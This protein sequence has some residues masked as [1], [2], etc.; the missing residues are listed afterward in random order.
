MSFC[1]TDFLQSGSIMSLPQNKLLL[2]WGEPRRFSTKAIDSHKPAFYFTDFFLTTAQPWI[3]YSQWMEISYEDFNYQLQS[4]VQPSIC[5]WNICKPEQFKQT[6]DELKQLLQTGQLQKGVP[7]L[8]AHSS[9]CMDEKRL[10]FCLAKS[11]DA[12]KH[13]MGYLYGHWHLSSGVLGLTPELLLSHTQERPNRVQTMALAGTCHPSFCQESFLKNEKERYEHQLVVEGISQSLQPFGTIKIKEIQLLHLPKL[14]HLMTPIEVELD[15]AF[16][17]DTLVNTLHP[18]PALG[19]YPPE[20][21]KKWLQH[22]QE[23]IPRHYYGAP[24]GFHDFRNGISQCVVGIRNV[25]WN[26]SGMRIGAGCGVIKQSSFDKEWQEIQLKIQS[27]R[28]QFN[29]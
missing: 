29:L 9:H 1:L 18:T 17:F 25:Q 26:K 2:G 15:H 7:Y 13:Q 23:Q 19:A 14:T 3:Q 4:V 20:E 10:Q 24:L 12:M 11:L 28:D 5:N 21:G 8:F 16:D 22:L 6:F 27:I